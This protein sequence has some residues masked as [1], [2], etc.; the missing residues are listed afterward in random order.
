MLTGPILPGLNVSPL[1]FKECKPAFDSVAAFFVE[2]IAFSQ[3]CQV[4]S[5]A[6]HVGCAPF[7]VGHAR[8]G[9]EAGEVVEAVALG[10]SVVAH[11]VAAEEF[12]EVFVFGVF[13]D[14]LFGGGVEGGREDGELAEDARGVGC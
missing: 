14:R 6:A 8:V 13:A 2:K 4:V 1:N 7:V 10:L 11:E 9:E 3:H 12:A 5:G